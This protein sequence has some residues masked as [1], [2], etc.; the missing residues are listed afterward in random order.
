MFN[1]SVRNADSIPL[2]GDSSTVYV[3]GS[4]FSSVIFQYTQAEP[5][6]REYLLKEYGLEPAGIP[7]NKTYESHFDTTWFTTLDY[8]KS[9]II[10]M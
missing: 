3:A 5:P 10:R 6:T 2:G 1:S 9:T 8:E 4:L 7:G